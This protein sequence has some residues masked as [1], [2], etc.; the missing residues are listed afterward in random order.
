MDLNAGKHSRFRELFQLRGLYPAILLA[1]ILLVFFL[2]AGAQPVFE[3]QYTASATICHLEVS[4]DKYFAMDNINNRCLIYNMDHTVY[5]TIDLVLPADYYMYNILHVSE[6]TFN[7]DELVEFAYIYSKY[8][9]TDT[10]WYYSY[11]TRVINEHGTEILKIP[12]AGHSE[13]L[14]TE[15]LGRKW[16]AY[17][18]DFSVLPA[19]TRTRVY[20]L[21]EAATKSD[22]LKSSDTYILENPWPNPSRGLVNIPVHLPPGSPQ[23]ELILYNLQGQE[24]YRR[25]VNPG[26]ETIAFPGG[27]L[28]PGAYVYK[29]RHGDLEPEGK[30]III[31]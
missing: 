24:L 13:I 26:E 19:T 22:A 27:S 25:A 8:T 12:G 28:I 21:P 2:P 18:Y 6:K 15:S 29:I 30:K 31:H 1:G 5:R 9:G 16:L 4:G 23:G 11:E 7:S 20:S 14:Q 3:N 10:S 17:I